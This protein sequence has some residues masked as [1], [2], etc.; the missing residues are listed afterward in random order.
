MAAKPVP[1]AVW[2]L[3]IVTWIV[4][5][6]SSVKTIALAVGNNWDSGNNNSGSALPCA[7]FFKALLLPKKL[8]DQPRMLGF[9]GKGMLHWRRGK[10]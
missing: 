3:A 9:E 6:N 1:L 8:Y 2:L 7:F 10:E 4:M 5:M